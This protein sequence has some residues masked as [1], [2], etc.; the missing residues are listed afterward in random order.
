MEDTDS[1]GWTPLRFLSSFNLPGLLGFHLGWRVAN[2]TRVSMHFLSVSMFVV[3]CRVCRVLS[4][5][6]TDGILVAHC[7]RAR[8]D[9][10][11]FRFLFL[12]SYCMCGCVESL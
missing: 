2:R 1:F 8:R 7:C 11:C 5:R 12:L 4:S 6:D 10:L 9:V 3:C